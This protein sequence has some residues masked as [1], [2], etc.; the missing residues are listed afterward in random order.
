[1]YVYRYTLS[2]YSIAEETI[3]LPTNINKDEYVD[4]LCVYIEENVNINAY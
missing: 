1:M 3:G 4:Y 2:E